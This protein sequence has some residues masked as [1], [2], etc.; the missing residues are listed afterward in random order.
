MNDPALL[1]THSSRHGRTGWIVLAVG[2]AAAV[3]MNIAAS[4]LRSA[5]RTGEENVIAIMGLLIGLVFC[6][7]AGVMG[8]R[9]LYFG[10]KSARPLLLLNAVGL[11]LG[12]ATAW[13]WREVPRGEVDEFNWAQ[14]QLPILG[15][16]FAIAFITGSLPIR[17]LLRRSERKKINSGA[18]PWTPRERARRA[19]ALAL[20]YCALLAPLLLPVPLYLASAARAKDAASNRYLLR[21]PD[22]IRDASESVLSELQDYQ[23]RAVQ[24]R[25]LK[26]GLVST[27][28]LSARTLDAHR[29]VADSALIGLS[30]RDPAW[31]AN[32]A[33]W[34]LLYGWLPS[35]EAVL[36]KCGSAEQRK[37]YLD[38]IDGSLYVHHNFMEGLAQGPPDAET[39]EKLKSLIKSNQ[40]DN[41][42]FI[43]LQ[44]VM[45]WLETSQL[46][47]YLMAILDGGDQTLKAS[48]LTAK[49]YRDDALLNRIMLAALDRSKSGLRETALQEIDDNVDRFKN[50]A[51][52]RKLLPLLSDQDSAQSG[53][54][55]RALL[56]IMN[57][58]S[59][60]YL[61]ISFWT[62]PQSASALHYVRGKAAVWLKEHEK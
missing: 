51:V 7:W 53:M 42:N 33:E 13:L 49:F 2:V 26:E 16:F 45:A 1:T 17:W 60:E 12:G 34:K 30:K 48:V 31:A 37:R 18:A 44:P 25:V 54:A 43:A 27:D 11:L 14:M 32:I 28:R 57:D 50:P 39:L 15:P 46:E 21:A 36:G 35:A 22:F 4:V 59:F 58:N 10:E 41:G 40:I 5:M 23:W 3:A 20:V 24:N 56:A 6:G 19:V 55:A 38:R 29:E 61:S 62:S 9:A 47:I 8:L 52:V